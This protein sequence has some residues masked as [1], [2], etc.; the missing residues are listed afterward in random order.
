MGGNW[1]HSHPSRPTK[2]RN[3]SDVQPKTKILIRIL[4]LRSKSIYTVPKRSNGGQSQSHHLDGLNPSHWHPPPP[5]RCKRWQ[6]LWAPFVGATRTRLPTLSLSLS[7]R[8]LTSQASPSLQ[9]LK[10]WKCYCIPSTCKNR[11]INS[12]TFSSGSPRDPQTLWRMKTCENQWK[13]LKSSTT[14]SLKPNLNEPWWIM[15]LPCHIL[16]QLHQSLAQVSDYD[17]RYGTNAP[18]VGDRSWC[19]APL[20]MRKFVEITGDGRAWQLCV[21]CSACETPYSI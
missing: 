1:L 12:R 7:P 10:R 20:W 15:H 21:R 9:K 11:Y 3:T 16:H 2:A 5:G 6:L 8:S 4:G 13:P 17:P 18:V 19:E 14:L